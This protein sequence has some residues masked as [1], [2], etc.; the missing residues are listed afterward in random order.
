MAADTGTVKDSNAVTHSSMHNTRFPMVFR[1][2]MDFILPVDF[3]KLQHGY[4]L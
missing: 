4:G 3:K 2:S 1:N